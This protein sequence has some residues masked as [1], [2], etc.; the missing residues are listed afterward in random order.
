MSFQTTRFDALISSEYEYNGGKCYF[1]TE[2]DGNRLEMLLHHQKYLICRPKR[3]DDYDSYSTY[4]IIN[5]N[6][7]LKEGETVIIEKRTPIN[8]DIDY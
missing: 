2:N 5:L 7:V 1:L 8:E 6:E 3:T 4:H